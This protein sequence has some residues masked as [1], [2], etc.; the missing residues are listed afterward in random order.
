MSAD[1]RDRDEAVLER[2]PDRLEHRARDSGSS[3]EKHAVVGERLSL[4]I[5]ERVSG[6]RIYPSPHE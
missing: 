6:G 1:T 3:D 2:L 5:V 4:T